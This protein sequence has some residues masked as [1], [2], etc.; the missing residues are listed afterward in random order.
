MNP[1]VEMLTITGNIET[2][3]SLGLIVMDD[4][5]IPLHGTSLQIVS[6]PSDTRNSEFGI[7]GWALSGLPAAIP[8]DQSELSIDGLRTSLVEPSAPLYAPH[9][10]TATGLD[11]VV[12]LTPDLERTSG[13]IADATGCELKRIREVGSMRQGFHRIS[14]G[15]LI[16]ELVERPDVP[17]GDAEFWGIV[18]IVDDLDGVCAQLGP[19][20]ISSPKD[21]VQPGRQIATVRGDVGLGLPVALMTP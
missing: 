7:A 8:P 4:G 3:R 15:G 16:V 11:H 1:K 10:M 2:W 5:T 17:P 9:E 13:A 14:P 12:V 19:E 20:R 6:A 18:I 21:A